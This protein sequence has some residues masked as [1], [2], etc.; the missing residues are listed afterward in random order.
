MSGRS[1]W[2]VKLNDILR[3]LRLN[4]TETVLEAKEALKSVY[5]LKFNLLTPQRTLTKAL[6]ERGMRPEHA[7][8][9]D[10]YEVKKEK[11]Y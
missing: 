8:S 7:F 3:K 1:P 4:F 2:S 6:S 11:H 9:M 5:I 10:I